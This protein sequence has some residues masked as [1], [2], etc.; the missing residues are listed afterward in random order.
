MAENEF[1][2][3]LPFRPP[4][5][6]FFKYYNYEFYYYIW[7]LNSLYPL[8]FQLLFCH[9][10]L[11]FVDV[12]SNLVLSIRNLQIKKNITKGLSQN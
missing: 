12:H 7:F 2:C 1:L 5:F 11:F 3:P 4:F 9:L 6:K 8:K 10:S